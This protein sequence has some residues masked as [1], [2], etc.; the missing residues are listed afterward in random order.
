MFQPLE[1]TMDDF[2]D[3]R[4]NPLGWIMANIEDDLSGIEW[5]LDD[6]DADAILDPTLEA[7][8]IPQFQKAGVAVP[9]RA[10]LIASINQLIKRITW[11]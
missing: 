3:L 7:Y 1:V 5:V 9:E 6:M 10:V 4:A 8:I 2:E 11:P